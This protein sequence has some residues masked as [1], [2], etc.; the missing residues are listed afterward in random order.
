MTDS[1]AT[2]RKALNALAAENDDLKISV[3]AFCA[4]WA[5]QYA[6]ERNL[7]D[8]HLCATHYDILKRAGARMVDFVRDDAA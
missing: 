6:K 8:G 5:V 3:V 7:P 4:P 2:I 1:I